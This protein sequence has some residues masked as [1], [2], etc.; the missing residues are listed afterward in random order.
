MRL[1]LAGMAIT[2][3]IAD[4]GG[5]NMDLVLPENAT[6]LD[7][8]ARTGGGNVTVDIGRGTAGIGVVNARSGAGNVVVRVPNG[9]AVRVHATTGMGKAI[10]DARFSKIDRGTY[11]SPD[12]DGAVDKIEITATSGAGNVSVE[13][14]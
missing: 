12:F 11:Q 9:L 1:D 3:V 8:A 10:M 13:T 7:V 5:G 2:R 6:N 14:K 4:S